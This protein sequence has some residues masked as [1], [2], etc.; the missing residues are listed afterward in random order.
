MITPAGSCILPTLPLCSIAARKDATDSDMRD[1]ALD[2]HM[3]THYQQESIR[4]P[5]AKK[6]PMP[7]I[8]PINWRLATG[9][10]DRK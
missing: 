10:L 3:L 4:W 8:R 2:L 9:S 5:S 6:R 1:R 7:C